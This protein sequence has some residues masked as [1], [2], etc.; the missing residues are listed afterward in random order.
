MV[1]KNFKNPLLEQFLISKV[2]LCNAYSSTYLSQ[3]RAFTKREKK[4]FHFYT[5]KWKAGN[6]YIVHLLN[7]G[8]RM[9]LR[10]LNLP[11]YKSNKMFSK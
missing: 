7:S 11:S 3:I 9:L 6:W 1:P 8:I 10:S 5:Q 2:K 4:V